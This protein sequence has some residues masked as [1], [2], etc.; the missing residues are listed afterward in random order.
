MTKL[1]HINE[2]GQAEMVDIS[3][4]K[5]TKRSAV[6]FGK[7]KM[8]KETI[9]MIMDGKSH[10]GDVLATARVAGI[11]AAKK[12]AELIPLCHQI[13]LS[14][15]KV[16]FKINEAESAIEIRSESII[17]DKTGVEMEALTAVSIAA[18]TLYD[19][20]KSVDREMTIEDIHLT[21]KGGGKSG[22][23]RSDD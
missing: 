5:I 8:K 10:K 12:T 2:M 15:I 23:Y 14:K 18:L 1:S 9:I 22:I 19:M 7:I 4:K 17:S 6:A 3:E 11:M 20:C 16:E 13:N 21:Y